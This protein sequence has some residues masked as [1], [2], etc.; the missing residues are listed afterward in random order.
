[1]KLIKGKVCV[2]VAVLAAISGNSTIEASEDPSMAQRYTQAIAGNFCPTEAEVTAFV[3]ATYPTVRNFQPAKGIVLPTTRVSI[4]DKAF[5]FQMYEHLNIPDDE[6][7]NHRREKIQEADLCAP[8]ERIKF[9]WQ[10]GNGYDSYLGLGFNVYIGRKAYSVAQV[11]LV[12]I[13]E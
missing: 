9:S 6:Y 1:M 4:A 2:A 5:Q 12:R 8:I 10:E 3:K 13:F 7:G 11:V